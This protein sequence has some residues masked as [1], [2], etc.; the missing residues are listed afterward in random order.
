MIVD[1]Q[2]HSPA[3]HFTEAEGAI[4]HYLRWHQPTKPTV[5]LVHG[6]A[7]HAHW[8]DAVAIHLRKD[9]DII[10]LDLSGC[11]DSEHRVQ[12]DYATYTRE[13]LAVCRNA[14]VSRPI[15]VG[16]SFGGTVA[17]I[18][19]FSEPEL[20]SR[21]TIIDS[22]LRA[23]RQRR[24]LSAT[25]Q[26][27]NRQPKIHFFNTEQEAIKRF[28]LR[29]SQRIRHPELIQHIARHAITKTDQGFRFKLDLTFLDRLTPPDSTYSPAEMLR[30]LAIPAGLI[31]GRDSVFYKDTLKAGQDNLRAA[32]ASFKADR[33][34][35]IND[36]A[37]HVLLDQPVETA[38]LIKVLSY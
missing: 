16:H 31:T 17:R 10:A 36:A 18:A 2:K 21:L 11:G 38:R 35:W 23:R 34:H 33:W 6:H 25:N 3:S 12:Y 14:D 28:R 24:G 1:I 13:L 15:I 37:H 20:A 19:C 4:I 8:W 22:P 29:P 9:F 32:R 27:T 5:L 26:V 7:A 30:Q